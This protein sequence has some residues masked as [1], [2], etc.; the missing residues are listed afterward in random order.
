MEEGAGEYTAYDAE[1]HVGEC[2]GPE[3]SRAT[4]L[5]L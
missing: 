5:V 1:I 4:V 2:Y 3:A